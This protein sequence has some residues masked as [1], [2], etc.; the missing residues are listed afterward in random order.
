MSSDL[1]HI[2][3]SGIAKLYSSSSLTLCGMARLFSKMVSLFYIYSI[4]LSSAAMNEG[5]NFSTSHQHLLLS[6]ILIT[7][8]LVYVKVWFAFLWG[9]WMLGI[10]SCA[11][12]SFVSFLWRNPVLHFFKVFIEFITILLLFMFCFFGQETCG[13]LPPQSGI[14][15]TLLVQFSSVTQSCPTLCSTPGLP[16]YHQLPKLTQTHIHWVGDAI[17][18]SHPLSF[19]SPPTFNLYQHQGLF[20]WISSSH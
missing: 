2:F 10:F 13:I 5:P 3:G 20:Q 18:P 12:W 1:L 8:L 16:V 15:P 9:L 14:E 4:L 17:Q 7:A 11:H 19:P 6:I